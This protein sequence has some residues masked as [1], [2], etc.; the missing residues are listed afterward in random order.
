MDVEYGI[1]LAYSLGV[2]NAPVS[3]LGVKILLGLSSTSVVVLMTISQF[4]ALCMYLRFL[5]LDIVM[6][7]IEKCAHNSVRIAV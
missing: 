5:V 2:L 3:H 7:S 1:P 6:S 4:N